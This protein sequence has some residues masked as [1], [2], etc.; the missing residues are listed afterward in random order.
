MSDSAK[1]ESAEL[2]RISADD[3]RKIRFVSEPALHPDGQRVVFALAHTDVEAN[4]YRGHL[5]LVGADGSRKPRQFTHGKGRDGGPI[6]SPD[7]QWLAFTATRAGHREIW[8]LPADGGEA[9]RLTHTPHGAGNPAWAPDSRAIAF[10]TA[11]GPEDPTPAAESFE[12]EDE[13][14][15]RKEKNDKARKEEPQRVTRL[16][17]KH[18]GEGYWPGR[19]THLWVQDLDEDGASVGAPRQITDGDYED[20]EP[21]WS[22]DGRWIAFTSG[23]TADP[24]RDLITDL[25]VVSRDGGDAQQITLARG[26]AGLAA[27]SPDGSRLA[28]VGHE[29]GGE[30]GYGSNNILYVVPFQPGKATGQQR[31]ELSAV[32]D[33]PVDN[34]V[35]SDSKIGAGLNF[36]VWTPD[37][38]AVFMLLSS[39]GRCSLYRFA[40]DGKRD[41]VE[42]IGGDREVFNPSFTP[43]RRHVA[44]T[45]S[46]PTH[47]RD[48]FVADLDAA[49]NLTAE[50]RLS[51]VNAKLFGARHIQPAEEIRY[52]GSEGTP[53]QGW[54]I[55]PPGFDTARKYPAVLCIHGGPHLMYGFSFF[56]EFQLLAAEGYVVFY[57]NPRGGQGYGQAFSDAIR[58]GWGVQDYDDLMVATDVLI[59]QGYV[60]ADRLGVSGGSYGGYM[61][62]WIIGHTTRFKAAVASRSVTNLISMYGSSDAGWVLEDWEF[63]PLFENPE[64]YQKL[65]KHSPIAYTPQIETPVLLT[66][67]DDDLRCH[68]MQAEEM[69]VSLKLLGKT[70]ELVHFPGSSHELSRAGAPRMRVGRLNAITGWLNRYL[71]TDTEQETPAHD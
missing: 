38:K 1:T 42:V 44:Y 71:H 64:A 70:A 49:G 22:P 14:K 45:G 23:R 3:I 25:F 4:E 32:L 69:F 57:T 24:D 52:E 53:L 60:D 58:G 43:D 27:W 47:P 11:Y 6:W 39:W 51:E 15:K 54:I 46:T 28:Y 35:L 26:I 17:F 61:T 59:A 34:M 8:L 21:V 36:P 20:G 41:P 5:W 56:H 50:R 29:R 63:T 40:A 62:L 67:G 19:Y 16:R 18:D 55:K 2:R 10:T 30:W 65:W 7:G 31:I 12:T 68:L 33:R 48:V 66:H 37:G 9:R 13:H